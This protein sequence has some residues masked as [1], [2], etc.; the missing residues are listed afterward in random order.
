[1][2]DLAF[3]KLNGEK[4]SL[5]S[6]ISAKYKEV[7]GILKLEQYQKDTIE[8]F[9]YGDRITK[10]FQHWDENA[11]GG[12]PHTWQGLWD[13]LDNS[14]LT[15]KGEQFFDFLERHEHKLYHLS[16]P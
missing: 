14:D 1:M 12:Y 4:F 6:Q 8:Q 15:E 2:H 9:A 7:E 16:K 3:M 10:V 13:I 5:L 11:A